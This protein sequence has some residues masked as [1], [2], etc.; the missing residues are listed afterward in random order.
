MPA[1]GEPRLGLTY[2][3]PHRHAVGVEARQQRAIGGERRTSAGAAQSIG[4]VRDFP[5]HAVDLD[6]GVRKPSEVLSRENVTPVDSGAG[7]R[8]LNP[9]P[10]SVRSSQKGTRKC[11]GRPEKGPAGRQTQ[12]PAPADGGVIMMWAPAVPGNMSQGAPGAV[13]CAERPVD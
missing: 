3:A 11:R 1:V 9:D 8:V 13:G 10:E 7:I 6:D 5:D 2:G 4:D 12:L